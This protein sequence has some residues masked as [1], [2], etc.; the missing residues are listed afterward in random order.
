MSSRRAAV[1]Y[2]SSL[3]VVVVRSRNVSG[4]AEVVSAPLRSRV[5]GAGCGRQ[6]SHLLMKSRQADVVAC[7]GPASTREPD[8]SADCLTGSDCRQRRSPIVQARA[9]R[10]DGTPLQATTGVSCPMRNRTGDGASADAANLRRSPVGLS[11]L[12][13]WAQGFRGVGPVGIGAGAG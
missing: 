10:L 9:R 2:Q 4:D 7:H 8:G 6:L 5:S 1:G 12:Y 13:A 11:D 3:A